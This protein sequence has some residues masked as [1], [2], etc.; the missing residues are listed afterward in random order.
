MSQKRRGFFARIADLFRGRAGVKLRNAEVRNAEVV[1]HNAI[2][3]RVRQC[4]SLKDAVGRLVY[5]RNRIEADLR[6]RSEELKLVGE[7]LLLAAEADENSRA[8]ALIRK[9]RLLEKEIER[10]TSEHN[11]LIAQ[12]ASA[13]EGLAEV[14]KSIEHLKQERDE[15]VARK[16]HAEARLEVAEAL[17]Q[18]TGSF[19]AADEAL[20]NVREAIVRLEQDADLDLDDDARIGGEVSM[21]QLRREAEDRADRE[22]LDA[23]K[24][25]LAARLL[26]AGQAVKS[27]TIDVTPVRGADAPV[28]GAEPRIGA[29]SVPGRP[30]E[31]IS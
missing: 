15:M 14:H 2:E 1:Y 6:R 5:L 24:D 20:E 8:L 22:A 19:A 27:R 7:S 4:A 29:R 13:K 26:P 28:G 10:L 17:Q 23:L 12:A 16:A 30:A 18:S 25:Q 21:A 9:Q 31:V 11:R 3:R